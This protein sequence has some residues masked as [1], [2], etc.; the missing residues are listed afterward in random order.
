MSSSGTVARP[1][2][3]LSLKQKCHES[4]IRPACPPPWSTVRT[5]SIPSRIDAIGPSGLNSTAIAAPELAVP[6]R[7]GIRDWQAGAVVGAG[8]VADLRLRE[9]AASVLHDLQVDTGA[10]IH[11]GV[12]DGTDIVHVDKLGG[13]SAIRVPTRVGTRF[14]A[15]DIALGLADCCA[16][17]APNLSLDW[18]VNGRGRKERGCPPRCRR[19]SR[20]GT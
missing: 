13:R 9:A 2:Q 8:D 15:T 14:A 20:R 17:A 1:S 18:L 16:P 12:L 19:R 7:P 11:L 10:V 6:L 3:V 4:I 5:T